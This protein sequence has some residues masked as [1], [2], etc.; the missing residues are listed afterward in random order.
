MTQVIHDVTIGANRLP[1]TSVGAEE[2]LFDFVF[3]A[4]NLLLKIMTLFNRP[5]YQ[6][7]IFSKLGLAHWALTG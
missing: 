3:L 2:A 4:H 7:R 5:I 1:A 6:K